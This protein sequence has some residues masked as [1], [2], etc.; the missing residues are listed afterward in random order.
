MVK[1]KI[2][3]GLALLVWKSH[4]QKLRGSVCIEEVD[5]AQG[6][7]TPH[8][9][10]GKLQV[11]VMVALRGRNWEI[12][13]SILREMSREVRVVQISDWKFRS[14]SGEAQPPDEISLGIYLGAQNKNESSEKKMLSI[15]KGIEVVTQTE[16]TSYL[17]TRPW[18]CSNACTFS[19]SW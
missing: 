1:S 16:S 17:L 15:G 7:C 2:I 3:T 14:S 9:I 13:Y 12:G 4:F 10:P 8:S 6:I 5:S 19:M 18:S 11:D